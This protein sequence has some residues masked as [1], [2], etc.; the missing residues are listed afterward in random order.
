VTA[1][2]PA[3]YLGTVKLLVGVALVPLL[4]GCA[5]VRRECPRTGACA[6]QP[7]RLADDVKIPSDTPGWLIRDARRFARWLGDPKPRELR[8][9]IGRRDVIEMRGTFV[10]G[11]SCSY[12]PG[13][14]PPRGTRARYV[15]DPRTR[16]V[17]SF[18]L[19]R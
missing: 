5:S 2:R 11:K 10:C 6:A 14:K 12:P 7:V 4:F 3:T 9:R 16:I 8:I 18:F 15:I 1:V 13:G 19:R 17:D